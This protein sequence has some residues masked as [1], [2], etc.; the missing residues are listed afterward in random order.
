MC[1]RGRV[2]IPTGARRLDTD[3]WRSSPAPNRVQTL[4]IDETVAA[5]YGTL[6]DTFHHLTVKP[7]FAHSGFC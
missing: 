5:L 2:V 7:N 6:V 3:R 4:T 1:A